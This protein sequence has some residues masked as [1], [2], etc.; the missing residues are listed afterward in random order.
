MD[1]RIQR[2]IDRIERDLHRRLTVAD[3]AQ[4]AELSVPQLTR[5]FRAATGRTPGMFLRDLRMYRARVL[6]ER[7]SLSIEE[8]MQQVGL[9]DRSRFARDF[10]RA[11][12]DSPRAFRMR[13]RE[14]RS[15]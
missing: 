2:V 6:L 11:H 14:R 1:T 4:T 7:T 13:M 15:G 3:L 9:A 12:G 10:R 5:L 8:V